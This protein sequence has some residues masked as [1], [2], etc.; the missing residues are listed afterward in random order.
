MPGLT[1]SNE[2]ISRDEGMHCDFACHLYDM[3]ENKLSD[4][5]IHEIVGD[6]VKHELT[7]VTESLPVSLIGMNADMM[8]EYIKFCA[9]RLI[10]QL[11]APKL[12]GAANPFDWSALRPNAPRPNAL[13]PRA[14]RLQDG[15]DQSPR[16]DVRARTT[17]TFECTLTCCVCVCDAQQLL[18]APRGRVPESRRD[19]LARLGVR[20]G[21][22]QYIFLGGGLLTRSGRVLRACCVRVAGVLRVCVQ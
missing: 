14:P 5:T 17:P 22:P 18:R 21:Q 11:G 6:A 16:K 10:V 12:Y 3:L 1:F 9:D 15:I 20:N 8:A 13:T 19:E 4:A 2:L 7:F